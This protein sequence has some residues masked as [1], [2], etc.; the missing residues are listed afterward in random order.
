MKTV[1]SKNANFSTINSVKVGGAGMVGNKVDRVPIMYL[2]F[3]T[4]FSFSPHNRCLGRY[5]WPQCFIRDQEIEVIK[6]VH[7]L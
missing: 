6:F 2:V 1:I 3:N 7:R 5:Y 4:L